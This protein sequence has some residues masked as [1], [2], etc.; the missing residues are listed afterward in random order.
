[1]RP[2]QLAAILRE[3]ACP[4]NGAPPVELKEKAM[5]AGD[6]QVEKTA[7]EV[8]L[9]YAPP[10]LINVGTIADVTRSNGNNSGM[11]SGYS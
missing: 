5:Q 4:A 7:E 11:D 6:E 1:M 8:R 10:D 2:M 9:P 3:R